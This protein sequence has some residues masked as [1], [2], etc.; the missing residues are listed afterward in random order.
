MKALR[1]DHD[2][3]N[4][5]ISLTIEKAD[6]ESKFNEELGKYRTKAHLKGFRK[7]KTPMTTIKRMYGKAV[8]ADTINNV[9]QEK[10]TGYLKD[11]KIE[12]LGQPIP[13]EGQENFDFNVKDLGN[14]EFLFDL[15]LAPE[16]DVKGVDET[17][18]VK[19]YKLEIPES[20]IMEE[21][22]IARKR[23]GTEI[24]PEDSIE[25]QDIL[26]IHAVELDG[27]E[28]KEG[29]W[30]TSFTLLV[31]QMADDKLKKK[32]LKM[33]KGDSFDFDITKI[34]KNQDEKYVRKYLLNLEEGDDR[35]IGS[36]FSGTINKISRIEPAEMNQDFFDK[37][38]GPDTVKTEEEAKAKVEE[39]LQSYYSEQ[40]KSLMFREI[41]DSL[42]EKNEME[43]PVEFLKRWLKLNNEKA[44]DEVIE[45]E[46]DPFSKNLKWNLIR[47]KL[48]KRF[49]V[50]AKPE[51]IKEAF[52]NQIQSYF[53]GNAPDIDLDAMADRL[54]QNNEQFSKVYEEVMAE[55]LF[56]AITEF[57]QVEEET[58]SLDDF[59]DLVKK[60]N[61]SLGNS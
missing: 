5:S 47:S 40:T 22:D 42:M 2:A 18:S 29:G 61:E 59:N 34:E 55:K 3:L 16:F 12:Y 57:I 26:T 30:Q 17:D 37:N 51:D 46:F 31:N 33:K 54:M 39:S 44:T 10:L 7:G 14:F 24:Y 56:T 48:E 35:E 38:F 60:M 6:Y 9:L 43:L 21:L 58:I 28:K 13:S 32:V 36:L 27:K 52:K 45:A 25:E 19:R 8:L 1:T 20:T 4:V 11:E 23:A 53:G 50:E 49:E 15:G 41:M